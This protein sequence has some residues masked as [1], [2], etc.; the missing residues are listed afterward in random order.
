[1]ADYFY[2]RRINGRLYGLWTVRQWPWQ[3]S[4]PDTHPDIIEWFS[5]NRAND[6]SP[7]IDDP[8]FT[9][10]MAV[11]VTETK[12]PDSLAIWLESPTQIR[13]AG[14]VIKLALDLVQGDVVDLRWEGEATAQRF[15]FGTGL[16]DFSFFATSSMVAFGPGMVPPDIGPFNTYPFGGTEIGFGIGQDISKQ[17]DDHY[18]PVSRSVVF[19][20][21]AGGT[22]TFVNYWWGGTND[23][24]G[25]TGNAAT[26]YPG[27]VKLTAVVHKFNA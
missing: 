25:G 27:S 10:P 4:L 14:K 6:S 16:F 18:Y 5:G 21:P 7:I 22:W 24:A 19:P 2:G 20:C 12:I 13:R 23:A 3:Q 15:P 8:R 26:L 17:F 1:M 9:F 11:Q